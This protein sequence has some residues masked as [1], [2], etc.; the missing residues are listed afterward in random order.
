MH[1]SAY[2]GEYHGACKCSKISQPAAHAEM[3]CIR[4][5]SFV[6]KYSS[7]C[8]QQQISAIVTTPSIVHDG[9]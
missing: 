5:H 8:P 6:S 4:D 7:I 9:C 3:Y 2:C 1:V